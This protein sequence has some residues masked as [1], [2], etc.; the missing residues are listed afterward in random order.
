SL[1]SSPRRTL[2]DLLRRGIAVGCAIA[3][4][5]SAVPQ[6]APAQNNLPALGDSDSAEFNVGAERKIG[7][8]IM[9]EVHL[10]PDYIDDPLLLEYVQSVWDPL[11]VAARRLGNITA[12]IDQRF[13][14]QP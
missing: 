10:D 6:P 11:V 12:D 9:R 13:T 3:V 5:L 14:W 2:R 1:L 4:A 8:E 7:D